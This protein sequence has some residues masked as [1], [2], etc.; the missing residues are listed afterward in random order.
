MKPLRQLLADSTPNGA[1]PPM[2]PT[3]QLRVLLLNHHFPGIETPQSTATTCKRLHPACW[4]RWWPRSSYAW[5][6]YTGICVTLPGGPKYT[7]PTGQRSFCAQLRKLAYTDLKRSVHR[8]TSVGSKR[9]L[10]TRLSVK[11]SC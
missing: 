9:R 4:T 5:P 10:D 3:H 6:A 7:G 1:A 11:N 2:L 8:S